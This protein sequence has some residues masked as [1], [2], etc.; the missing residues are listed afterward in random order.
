MSAKF[1]STAQSI[2]TSSQCAR[3]SVT[4]GK[5]CTTSPSDEVFTNKIVRMRH[6]SGR[7]RGLGATRNRHSEGQCD[8]NTRPIFAAAETRQDETSFDCRGS[9]VHLLPR[10]D[11]SFTTETGAVIKSI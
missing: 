2:S 4:T 9:L 1:S 8:Y 11:E 5:L 10:Q 7:R 6:C 3:T